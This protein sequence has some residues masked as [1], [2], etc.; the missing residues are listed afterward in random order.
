MRSNPA[1]TTID[2]AKFMQLLEE[3]EAA[4]RAEN[5]NGHRGF[6]WNHDELK[7]RVDGCRERLIKEVKIL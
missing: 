5:D 2:K 3:F 6:S 1:V 7:A 4:V